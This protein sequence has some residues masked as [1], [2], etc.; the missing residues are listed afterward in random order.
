T[1]LTSF[2][3]LPGTLAIGE[4]IREGFGISSH[5]AG[6]LALMGTALSLSMANVGAG[7]LSGRG[8]MPFALGGV[9]AWWIIG[10]TV[11]EAGWAP[12]VGG[13]DLVGSVYLTMLRPT[14][15]GILI[16]GALAGVVAAFPAL[17]G[18]LR[19]LSSASKLSRAGAVAEELSPKVLVIGITLAFLGLVAVA[20]TD[21]RTP[22]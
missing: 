9:L 13:E 3:V 11:V 7:L 22:D 6:A 17:R 2:D 8:G 14:G 1:L 16:G 21:A 10:P 4:A 18:A 15:I 12:P 19:S 5:G 20:T